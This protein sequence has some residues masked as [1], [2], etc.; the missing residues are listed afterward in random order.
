[1]A[2]RGIRQRDHGQFDE[3]MDVDY[4]TACAVLIDTEALR[5]VG[6]FDDAYF[7]S[8]FEDADLCHRARRAG[9]RLVYEPAAAAWHRVSSHSGGGTTPLK[10]TLRL[11][12]Q[13]IF[14]RRYAAWYH[15]VTIPF[16]ASFAAAGFVVRCLLEGRW[17]LVRAV[18]HGLRA[19]LASGSRESSRNEGRMTGPKVQRKG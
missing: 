2:H 12:N 15:W 14:F 18:G 7:P 9:F 3:C 19:A 8:Y 17:Q 5:K 13:L 16:C 10:V 1:V 4:L 6:M 11:R